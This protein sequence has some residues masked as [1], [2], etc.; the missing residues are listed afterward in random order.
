MPELTYFVAPARTGR[1]HWAIPPYQWRRARAV[2]HMPLD[3]CFA[4]D[5]LRYGTVDSIISIESSS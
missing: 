4:S 3:V 1:E 5:R 2:T